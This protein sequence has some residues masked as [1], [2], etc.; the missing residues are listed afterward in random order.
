MINLKFINLKCD[1][2]DLFVNVEITN[3]LILKIRDPYS[4]LP[5]KTFYTVQ[6]N[7]NYLTDETHTLSATLAK[8]EDGEV[9]QYLLFVD[10]N[11]QTGRLIKN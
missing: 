4:R 2:G 5:F 6:Y 9:K 3:K 1:E 11:E 7:I 10:V 8:V